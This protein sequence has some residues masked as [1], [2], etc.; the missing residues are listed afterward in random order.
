MRRTGW[1]IQAVLLARPIIWA[2]IP[3]AH[4]SG[5]WM[6]S[7]PC[8]SVAILLCCKNLLRVFQWLSGFDS[9]CSIRNEICKSILLFLL[10]AGRTMLLGYDASHFVGYYFRPHHVVVGSISAFIKLLHPYR[11]QQLYCSFYQVSTRKWICMT[12]V[13]F[14]HAALE[15]S[16]VAR[17]SSYLCP[18]IPHLWRHCL[19][20]LC[21]R[22]WP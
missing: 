4:F 6:L 11:S 16:L 2:R 19:A 15:R 8:H 1:I 9:R 20:G 12:L 5:H 22:P 14:W 7:S 10:I 13:G 17:L 3:S 18:P 21:L